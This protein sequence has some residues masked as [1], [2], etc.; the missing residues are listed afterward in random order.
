MKILAVLDQV[1]FDNLPDETV[2]GKDS[3][4]KDEKTNT[5]KLAMDGEE[6]GKLA[7]QL[8][9]QLDNKKKELTKVHDEKNELADRLQVFEGLGKSADEIKTVLA[10]GQPGIE[11]IE[12][13]HAKE[14][15]SLKASHE[16]ALRSATEQL[17]GQQNETADVKRHLVTEM[18]RTLIA[19][20]KNEFEMNALG[21]D[22]LSNRI[23]IVYDD[24]AGKY[25]PRVIENGEAAYKAGQFKTPK[26]LVEEAQ[27]N[28][29]YAGMFNAGTAAGSGAPTRQVAG[30]GNGF[31]K[32]VD[33]DAIGANLERIASGEVKVV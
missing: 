26:Q 8:Q 32:S 30:S 29:D 16:Q 3:Y 15:K 13:K 9:T 28:K 22:W 24:D 25:L 31:V 27:A 21:D 20:L 1:V 18:K 6:A 12:T 14:I 2:L 17:E 5:F 7:V 4:Q 19:E 11:E 33:A 10:T 23:E